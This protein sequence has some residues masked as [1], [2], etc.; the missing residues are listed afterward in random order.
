MQGATEERLA[1][2]AAVVVA[3]HVR[4]V[5]EVAS[6]MTLAATVSRYVFHP[7][8]DI[9][10]RSKRLKTLRDLLATQWLPR[11]ELEKVQSRRLAE[12]LQFAR[13]NS[14]Y[15]RHLF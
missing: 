15:Y 14:P 5:V 6:V 7:L 10:D 4:P 2:S 8:W 13:N 9:K 12:T 1:R 3:V 11:S